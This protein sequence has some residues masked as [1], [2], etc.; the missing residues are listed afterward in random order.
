MRFAYWDE[1]IAY[2]W[3]DMIGLTR[4][5]E[6][7]PEN[8]LCAAGSIPPRPSR[9]KRLILRDAAKKMEKEENAHP[10]KPLVMPMITT[11]N[12]R[13]AKQMLEHYGESNLHPES[14]KALRAL[15]VGAVS[16][17]KPKRWADPY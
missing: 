3:V 6:A 12:P 13:V 16:E 10:S 2:R 4:S 7:R 11:A 15:S 14:L 5:D 9:P 8:L 1:I 17:P